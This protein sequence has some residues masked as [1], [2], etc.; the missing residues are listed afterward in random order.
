MYTNVNTET[1]TLYFDGSCPVNPGGVGGI[2]VAVFKGAENIYSHSGGLGQHANMTNNVAEYAAL[3]HGLKWFLNYSSEIKYCKLDVYGDSK[4]VINQMKG[5]WGI[6]DGNYKDTAIKTLAIVKELKK[7][8]FT[9][10]F[11]WIPRENNTMCDDLSKS[12]NKPVE[13]SVEKYDDFSKYPGYFKGDV[14]CFRCV[15]CGKR[16]PLSICKPC[17]Q[18]IY[19][20]IED[21]S[22]VYT[23]KKLNNA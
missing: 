20:G 10:N 18:K 11:T 23:Y 14:N 9:I 8:K 16:N 3:L 1:F 2:G 17:K 15:K 7:R 19:E 12:Y 4:L 13:N 21:G 6:H 5:R 22:Y